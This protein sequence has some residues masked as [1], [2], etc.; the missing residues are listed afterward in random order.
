MRHRFRSFCVE[1]VATLLGLLAIFVVLAL[2]A[3][4]ERLLGGNGS[5]ALVWV[6]LFILGLFAAWVAFAGGYRMFRR[7]GRRILGL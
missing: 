1:V 6:V 5:E 7:L 3:G 4:I 2:G